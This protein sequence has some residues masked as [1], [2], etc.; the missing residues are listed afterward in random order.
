MRTQNIRI[1][2]EIRK[3]SCGYFILSGIMNILSF[4]F[5]Q[6][7]DQKT[8]EG[9]FEE[10]PSILTEVRKNISRDARFHNAVR[11]SSGPY[12]SHYS[13]FS[14]L[15]CAPTFPCFFLKMP[16]YPYFLVQKCLKQPKIFFPCSH[17]H[18]VCKN[19][20]NLF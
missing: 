16:Y 3:L 6:D 2:G 9:V 14:Q 11:P 13:Y 17:A 19:Q 20:I 5:M 15:F 18:S 10:V 7:Y 12:F 1:L 4:L 8:W